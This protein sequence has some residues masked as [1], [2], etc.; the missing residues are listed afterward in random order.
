M[1]RVTDEGTH[2]A[3][4]TLA[5]ALMVSVLLAGCAGDKK[6]K[7]P[8]EF[9]TGE[10]VSIM[11]A[12]EILRADPTIA[13]TVIQL[14][15]PLVQAEWP[16]PGG[17]ATNVLHHVAAKA[18]LER[19]WKTSIG[20]GNST[21]ARVT[22][23]PIVADGK[24]FGMDARARISALDAKSGK[25]IWRISMAPEGEKGESGFGG[26]L[27]YD[28]DRLFVSN[29][30]GHVLALDPDTGATIWRREFGVPF[31][32]APT[33]AAGRVF[34][35]T[36]DNQLHAISSFDGSSLWSHRAITEAAGILSDTNPAVA[37][38]MVIAPFSSGEITAIRAQNGQQ[39]W[40]DQLTKSG[41]QTAI[42]NISSIAGRPAVDTGQIIAISHSGRLV[43]IDMR[44][45]ER[46]WTRNIGGTQTPWISGGYIYVATSDAQIIC[47]TRTDGRIRWIVQLTQF[48]SEGR[49][50]RVHWNGPLLAGDQLIAFS[51]HGRF[52]V[53]SPYTGAVLQT[54]K[55]GGGVNTAPIVAGG[56]IYVLNEDAEVVAF[57]GTKVLTS[58]DVNKAPLSIDKN[59]IIDGTR[60]TGSRFPWFGNR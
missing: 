40:T 25:R 10:R 11:T 43:A 4:K 59:G 46:M 9:V 12:S 2:Q 16:Q 28:M 13:D 35:T 51:S 53:L 39:T 8:K 37:G 41:R 14:P 27:S 54:G 34:V 30:F 1:K 47:L 48:E 44:S 6:S 29:G 17:N 38:D 36:V 24:V 45:G 15:E 18:D 22:A 7:I 20:K 55:S 58:E 52:V 19:I 32:F 21:T 56:I 31:H 26:G 3:L 5:L 23:S 42:S 50:D 49:D 33:V 60:R 57:Q